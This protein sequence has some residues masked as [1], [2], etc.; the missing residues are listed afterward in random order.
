V[1]EVP[2][3]LA[4]LVG[5]PLSRRVA[6]AG[7]VPLARRRV[8]KYDAVDVPAV[9]RQT[10]LDLVSK[11]ADTRFGRD[12]DFA[13][14]RTVEDYQARV[15]VRDYEAFWTGYW[16][17]SYPDLTGVTWPTPIPYY[18]LSSG[19]TSGTTKFVPVSAEMVAANKRAAYTTLS[20]FR[21]IFPD[22]KI[23]TGKFFFLGGSTDLRRQADGSLAGDLSGIAA[24]EMMEVER[25]FTFPPL[26]LSLITDWDVKL[27]RLAE[28][29]LKEPITAISGVPSWMLKVFDVVKQI[30]G[31]A[32]VAE[33]WPHL[34]LVIHG[35]TLFDPY[36]ETFRQAV[37]DDRV[38]TLEVYPCSEGFVASEDPRHPGLLRVVPDHG[39]FFEFVPVAELDTPKPTRHTLATVETGLQYA[40]VLTTCAGLWSYLLGDTVTFESR[41]PP[42]IRFT[43]RT[44]YFLSA[45]GEHL[46]QE[47]VDKAVAHA[48]KS[49]GVLTEDHHVGPVFP[50]DPGKPGH[51][52]YFVEFRGPP[53]ARLDDF[54][55]AL[56]KEL[57][58]LNEDYAVH[59]VGNITMLRPEVR[60]V[61]PGGFGE[62]M[63]SRGKFGGQHKVPR[64]DNTGKLTTQLGD[65]LAAYNR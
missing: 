64:M 48:A 14:I 6:D 20:L 57:T 23:L 26:E 18:A 15:P 52:R 5:L 58:R 51:H 10:L 50:T 30:S 40:V 49:C 41:T 2:D 13:S 38:K 47:E 42:L 9:Q 28:A 32:T 24:K 53:P 12:H 36:R 63:K 7:F 29:S 37:G 22:A 61:P 33:A 35:G 25:P 1:Q 3:M 46:I 60:V 17:A 59:R 54:V 11:A 62:W 27:R 16:Q 4:S 45:F 39:L 34:R 44:K 19:T 65:W 56:D 21:N 8:R 43:G 55:E 31:K